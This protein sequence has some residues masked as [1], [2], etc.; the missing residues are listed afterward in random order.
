MKRRPIHNDNYEEYFLL[1]VDNE[2]TP[3]EREQVDAFIIEHPDL[4]IELQMLLDTKLDMENVS[5]AG[6]E[7]LYRQSEPGLITQDNVEEFQVLLLDG[8]LD[9]DE[10][11]AL[12]QYHASHSDAR[13]NFDWLKKAKLPEE[14]VVF[15]DKN[16]LYRSAQK[17]APIIPIKWYRIAAA[18]AVVITA[19]L[20]WFSIQ[21]DETG[22][23]SQDQI[24]QMDLPERDSNSKRNEALSKANQDTPESLH[25]NE[26]VA[27]SNEK[28]TVSASENGSQETLANQP[29]NPGQASDQPVSVG[30]TKYRLAAGQ[31]NDRL[32]KTAQ[33]KNP[34]TNAIAGNTRAANNGLIK[35]AEQDLELAQVDRQNKKTGDYAAIEPG[36]KPKPVDVVDKVADEYMTTPNSM[37]STTGDRNV[38]KNYASDALNNQISSDGE[39]DMEP[40]T[41]QR[42]GLRGIVR[43]ANRF[44]NKVTNPDND[45]PMVKVANFEIGLSR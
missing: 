26:T 19:G 4:K 21:D 44:Y 2:L 42:K 12:G 43:K 15:P 35:N 36:K 45:K 20:F 37:A 29:G 9:Q 14:Q 13:K 7:R 40:D 27:G 33:P 30:Q 23:E 17:T 1:Y 28:H 18:A 41:N 11:Q 5:M 8:E 24:V 38:K 32:V 10:I 22:L 34:P 6:R 16:L 39:E 25:G 31:T 3:A